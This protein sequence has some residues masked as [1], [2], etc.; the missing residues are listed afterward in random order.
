MPKDGIIVTTWPT[1]GLEA[2]FKNWEYVILSRE[3]KLIGLYLVEPI[4]MEKLFKRN[5]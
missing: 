4:D 1:E 3:C 2:M 5:T